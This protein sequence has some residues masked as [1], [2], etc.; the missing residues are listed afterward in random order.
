[1][2]KEWYPVDTAPRDGM[3]IILWIENAN[4]APTYPVT[5]GVWETDDITGRSCW[6]VFGARYSTQAY[7]DDHIRGWTFL[8][9][10]RDA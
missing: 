6:R 8:P 7:F 9:L 1:M 5:V 10:P 4:A 3:P 2:M